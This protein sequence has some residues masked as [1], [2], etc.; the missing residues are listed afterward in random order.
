M[1]DYLMEHPEAAAAYC[2]LKVR[3]AE[4]YIDDSL[5]YTKAKTGFIQNLVDQARAELG[6]APIKVWPD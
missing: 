4:K 1:R 5:A 2:D 6:L 3:L